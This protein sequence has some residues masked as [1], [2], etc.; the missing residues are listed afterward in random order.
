MLKFIVRPIFG[1]VWVLW[2][3]H[4]NNI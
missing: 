2:T 4:A 1:V 3:H